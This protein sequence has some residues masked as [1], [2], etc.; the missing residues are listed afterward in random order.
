MEDKKIE[1]IDRKMAL[2]LVAKRNV[3]VKLYLKEEEILRAAFAAENDILSLRSEK[4]KTKEELDKLNERYDVAAVETEEKIAGLKDKEEIAEKAIDTRLR[5]KNEDFDRRKLALDHTLAEIEKIVA[6]SNAER[7]RVEKENASAIARV[8]E[9]Y[10]ADVDK[11]SGEKKGLEDRVTGL[12]A[13][14]DKLVSR[15]VGAA[16]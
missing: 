8:K 4:D 2:Q 1:P 12:R 11:L 6:D 14:L 3:D 13:E 9:S 15:V 10:R 7:L 16:A 5:E